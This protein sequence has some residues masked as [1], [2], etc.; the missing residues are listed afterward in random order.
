LLLVL[1]VAPSAAKIVKSAQVNCKT[2]RICLYWWP[3]LPAVQGWHTDPDVNYG[4]GENGVNVLIPNGSNFANAGAFIY[5]E[6]I[7]KPR[8]NFSNPKTKTLDGFIADDEAEF[9]NNN[10]G[11]LTIAEAAPLKTGDG[12]ILRSV[13]Y[14]RPKAKNWERVSFGQEGD[15]YL[16]F[17]LNAHSLKD[18]DAAQRTYESLLKLYKQ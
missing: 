2:G 6:A 3:E 13:T 8:Y 1:S 4:L 5:A 16:L 15:Y 11:D 7:Y 9:R 17:T 10:P 12:Q 14:F 18:Y